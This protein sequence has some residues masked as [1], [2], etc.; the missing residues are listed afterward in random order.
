MIADIYSHM[1]YQLSYA[2]LASINAL[3]GACQALPRICVQILVILKGIRGDLDQTP[4]PGP[5]NMPV[6]SRGG[7]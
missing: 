7:G 4:G 1:L 2:E 5:S 3:H 6:G